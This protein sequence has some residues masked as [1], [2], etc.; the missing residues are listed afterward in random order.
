MTSTHRDTPLH[1]S[2]T[3][4]TRTR[5]IP[6][7][8]VAACWTATATG[9][10]AESLWP[11]T[12]AANQIRELGA[13]VAAVAI[14]TGALIIWGIARERAEPADQ[15]LFV[16][17][18]TYDIGYRDGLAARP[19]ITARRVIQPRWHATTDRRG[20]HERDTPAGSNGWHN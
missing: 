12:G 20:D 5:H 2:G 15:H 8:A 19:D 6:G 17:D 13:L 7:L 11:A 1:H 14:S 10:A 4:T 9:I 3:R 18:I 16:H